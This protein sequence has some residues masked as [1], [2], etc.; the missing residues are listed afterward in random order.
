MINPEQLE[1]IGSGAGFVAALDQSGG[2]TP[3]MLAAYGIPETAYNDDAEMFDLVHQMRARIMTS[4]PFDRDRILA[5][6]LFEDTMDRLVDGQE[7]AQYL[8]GV[9]GVVPFIKID[10]GL[11]PEADG[12][13]L[14]RPIPSL[15][16]L[17]ARAR[18]LGVFG[19]KMRSFIR[20]PDKEGISAVVAQQFELAVDVLATGLV[21][22]VEPEIDIH[23]A[24]KTEAEK[25]LKQA[26]REA[27]VSLPTDA[28]VILKLSL[29]SEDDFYA[30]LVADVRVLRVL[31]LSGGF[32][33]AE[34]VQIL[35]RNHSLIASFSRALLEGLD[36]SQS[37]D[38]FNSTLDASIEQIVQASIILVHICQSVDLW[39]WGDTGCRR[40]A[41]VALVGRPPGHTSAKS[42]SV[43]RPDQL[44]IQ[45]PAD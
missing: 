31:A 15:Q 14:M 44:A 1:R 2:S 3:K 8:W 19:T 18:G 16:P 39:Q 27:L 26:I 22:I 6:I 11:Q 21:P 13:H 20:Q 38:D 12:V 24:G 34:A 32:S 5:V 36:V 45:L 40:P 4:P 10:K 43:A 9:K 30:D 35:A 29:P 17:L 25:L 33:R 7:T 37:D 28:Q 42:Q 23:S 41:D